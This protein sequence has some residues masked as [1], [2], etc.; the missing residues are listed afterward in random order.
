V[1][2]EKQGCGCGAIRRLALHTTASL[3][4]SH[5]SRRLSHVSH[6]AGL[7]RISREEG[8]LA[9]WRGNWANVLRYF[10]TQAL[11]FAF[12]DTYRVMFLE[13][14]DKKTQFWRYFAGNLAA[15]GAAG[16]TSLLAVYPLD[17]ARTRLGADMGHGETRQF[18]GLGDCLTKIV[19]AV[20]ATVAAL[21]T[22]PR[23]CLERFR[24]SP[25]VSP[26]PCSTR[27]TDPTLCSHPLT[28]PSLQDG[29]LGLYRGFLV[30]LYGIIVYRAVFFGGYDT[31]KGVLLGP[32]ASVFSS[33]V[34][35]QTV[36]AA[37]GLIAYPFDTVRRRMMMDAGK[38][39]AERRYRSTADCWRTIAA[40]EGAR[41]F[42]NGAVANTV[43][44][45]GAALVLVIYDELQKV[46]GGG[47]RAAAHA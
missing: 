9:L 44:G 31:A 36:T 40:K 19:K 10:P 7:R 2:A 13:G 26:L 28:G 24:A 27:S 25:P 45:S 42:M 20:S 4:Q 16:A 1:A 17:F 22:R 8:T 15:G 47:K 21:T 34:A 46:L 14:V 3:H 37:A 43:R 12:K 23:G 6:A 30:S 39:V 32:D 38:A 33:W 5:R 29:F 35:A 18:K 11:N 41:G